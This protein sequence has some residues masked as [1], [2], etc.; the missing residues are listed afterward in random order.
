MEFGIRNLGECRHISPLLEKFLSPK[1]VFVSDSRKVLYNPE[2]DGGHSPAIDFTHSFELAGPREKIY[3]DPARV[4]CGIVTCGGLC[5]GLNDV[6]RSIVM[7]SYYRYGVRSITG[8]RYGYNGLNPNKAIEP[9]MLTPQLVRN[10]HTMGGTMLGSSRGGTEDIGLLVDTLEKWKINILYTIGGDGTLR[11]AKE[12]AE[13]ARKRGLDLA[14][15]GIPKTI[16]ND[17]S[18]IDRSF[19]YQTA[20]AEAVHSI[21]AAHVEAE[22]APNGIG[23]VKLMGRY[24]G[25]IAASTTLAMN[26]VNFCLIPEVPLKLDAFFSA[27]EDRILRRGH[28]VICAAE[29]VG[30]DLLDNT[31]NKAARDAS[32]NVVFKD[33]GV[34][35]KTKINEYFDKKGIE[36]NL[37]YIDPS[38]I[39]RSAPSCPM[40]A[41]FCA[42][43]GQYAVHAGMAGK[44]DIVIGRWNNMFTH[45]PIEL[46][47][48]QRKFV[49]INSLFWNNVIEATGQP[50]SWDTD[51]TR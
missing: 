13:V 2:F 45:V 50:V 27:L 22:G 47:I 17:I 43:L 9:V 15:V 28:A 41:I 3:F 11:G 36:I 7:Q 49:D 31:S 12:I 20:V 5:P 40:D 24:S 35:L 51:L 10:I 4:N 18:F 30:Q 39:I 32:N 6:I 26:D 38:Y 37:K 42:Q 46:A 33:I 8:I 34:F 16:D 29:G 44:T 14:V 23:L 25:F 48:S 1:S 21:Y 19:G